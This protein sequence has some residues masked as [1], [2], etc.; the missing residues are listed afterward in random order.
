MLMHELAEQGGLSSFQRPLAAV[1]EILHVMEILKHIR[2]RLK[3]RAVLMLQDASGITRKAGEEQQEVVFEVV[4]GFAG[5]R[6]RP[7]VDALIGIE[8]EAGDSAVGGNI[9][10]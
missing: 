4:Q 10:I 1:T 7:R 2:I 8:G 3:G 5:E 6:E 9:L